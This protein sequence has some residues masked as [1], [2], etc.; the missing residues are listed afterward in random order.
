MD[1]SVSFFSLV[2]KLIIRVN[3]K[4]YFVEP[5]SGVIKIP[6]IEGDRSI[7]NYYYYIDTIVD[8]VTQKD[9]QG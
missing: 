4:K 5:K 1:K 9:N 7:I 6:P 8:I 2:I 3:F